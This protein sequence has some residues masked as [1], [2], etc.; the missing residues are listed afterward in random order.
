M[1]KLWSVNGKV[2]SEIG[3]FVR[4]YLRQNRRPE[5][6][7]GKGVFG[8]MFEALLGESNQISPK[9]LIDF[10]LLGVRKKDGSPDA[11]MAYEEWIKNEK[12]QKLN[13]ISEIM[14]AAF[15]G[16]APVGVKEEVLA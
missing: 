12:Q 7:K 10:N 5:N 1:I 11:P 13:Q 2:K 14:G 3:R 9:N 6:M 4:F 16:N 8:K 15:A